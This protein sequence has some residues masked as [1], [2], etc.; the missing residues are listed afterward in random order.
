[1]V[2]LARGLET[3]SPPTR[4]VG[5]SGRQQLRVL[6]LERAQLVEQRVVGVVGDLGVVEDVVPVAVVG[7]LLAQL[8]GARRGWRRASLGDLLGGRREQR[9]EVVGA[10]GLQAVRGGEVEVQRRDRDAAGRDR[11]EVGAR[12]VVV[13]GE[14]P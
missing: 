1:M 7:E 14:S 13:D 12:L 11:G 6:A 10:Q 4:W 5:E 3:G 9:R 2:D 8:R